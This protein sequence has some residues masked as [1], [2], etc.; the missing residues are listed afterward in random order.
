MAELGDHPARI[1]VVGDEAHHLA[2]VLR[3]RVAD[4][5]HV[6]D[7]R[8]RE[9]RAHVD[10][11][12]K[13]L[14]SLVV[15]SEVR[16]VPEPAVTV[17]L[18]VGVLKGE[19]MDAVVRDATVMGVTA[20]RP[21]VTD[22]VV[23]PSRAWRDDRGVDRWHRVAVAAAKQCGRAVVPTI[24]AV[25]SLEALWAQ[26]G[27]AGATAMTLACVEPAAVAD[28]LLP[29]WRGAARPST[30]LVLVGPEGGWSA[31]ELA[32]FATRQAHAVSLGPRT[33]RA[34]AA[35]AVAMTLLWAAWGWT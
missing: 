9:W 6:F 5:V 29:D 8:G 19:Q 1:D 16:P 14:V 2:R 20:I 13:S 22:H 7:G 15:E 21:M 26:T 32:T 17:T 27:D 3:V 10:N 28:G 31:G 24:S 34:E 12:S 35:P 18:A 25:T 11:I 23:V 33:L 4:I 30:A